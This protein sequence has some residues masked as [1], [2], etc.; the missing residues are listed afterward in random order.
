MI[1][2]YE[3]AYAKLNLTLDVLGLRD[4]GYHDLKSVMQTVSLC[5]DI[6]LE[7]D[8]GKPWQLTCD[9][10][11]VPCDRR[12]LA[13]KAADCFINAAG[14]SVEGL[15]IHITKRIPSQAGMGGG[16][17][18]AAAVMRALNR[19]YG[20]MFS[21]E[22]LAKLSEQ[23]GS[24]VP[25]CVY[26]GTAMCEGRG[27]RIR[28]LPDMPA[29]P[30]VIC[31]PDFSLSTPVLFRRLDEFG[32]SNRPDNDAMEAAICDGDLVAVGAGLCN[33]FDP[34]VSSAFPL[35]DQVR[36]CCMAHV[37][38]GCQMSGSGSAFFALMPDDAS[39]DALAT[40]L[41]QYCPYI[42]VAY[43]V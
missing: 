8:T 7:L 11:S 12:N 31:K 33:V 21:V 5:D 27:E 37:A 16:S 22:E 2:L 41:K 13:W 3:K 28:K 43:P 15:S 32:I 20:M 35:M 36:A 18:D 40:A 14:I 1:T 17:S 4:D 29:C 42:F 23:I 9:D 19:H 24:D 34:V 26:G 38:L 39:A 30:I 6:L 10:A 25:F